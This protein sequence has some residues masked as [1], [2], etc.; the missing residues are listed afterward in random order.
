[1]VYLDDYRQGL[2][3]FTAVEEDAAEKE[4]AD[5]LVLKVYQIMHEIEHNFRQ[6]N[7]QACCI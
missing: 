2:V 3:G 1:M 5:M 4:I 6:Y 7:L